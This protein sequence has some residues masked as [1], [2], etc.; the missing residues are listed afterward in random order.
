ML[1][2]IHNRAPVSSEDKVVRKK[3]ILL[4]WALLEC[5]SYQMSC[6]ESMTCDPRIKWEISHIKRLITT[7]SFSEGGRIHFLDGGDL[8]IC[9]GDT[10]NH[11]VLWEVNLLSP[12]VYSVPHLFHSPPNL[13]SLT[14]QWFIENGF[15]IRTSLLYFGVWVAISNPSHS[16]PA[17]KIY[18]S[19]KPALWGSFTLERPNIQTANDGQRIDENR[20]VTHNFC[21]NHLRESG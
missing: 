7:Q 8:E 20:A 9:H 19:M 6:P 1:I 14:P 16:L 11:Q 5:W 17:M 18:R 12:L 13:W 4:V 3:K 2:K 21:S 10:P 15:L